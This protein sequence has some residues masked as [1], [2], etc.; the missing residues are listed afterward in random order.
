MK[1]KDYIPSHL[2]E[3]FDEKKV[4]KLRPYKNHKWTGKHFDE[5]AATLGGRGRDKR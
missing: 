1:N 5:G 2:R 3:G 4:K